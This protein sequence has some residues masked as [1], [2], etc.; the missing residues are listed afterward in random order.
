MKRLLKISFLLFLSL[1]FLNCSNKEASESKSSETLQERESYAIAIHGGAGN[2]SPENMP[3]ASR[4]AYREKLQEALGK[5]ETMLQDGATALETVEQVI[6]ILE[7]SPLFNAGKGAVFTHDGHNELDASIMD[8][9]NLNAG[10]VAGVTDIKNP[11]TAAKHVMMNS[12]HVLLAGKGASEFARLQNLEIVEPSYFHTEKR[13]K[14]LQRALQ[15]EKHGTVGCVVLD[16]HGNLAA[17]TS[18]GGRTNKK[19]GR[20]GDSPIIGAGTYA[21]NQT[22]AVSATGH[23]EYFIRYCVA[24]DI[25][26]LM[27]YKGLGLQEAAD[28]VINEKL[29]EADGAGGIIAVDSMGNI[30]FSFNTTMMFRASANSSGERE[31]AIFK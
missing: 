24:H 22:C 30:T 12:E 15:D 14:S 11:I 1:F 31:I 7:N 17:G 27:Q 29:V 6:N 3:E 21:N 16:N 23:G 28:R 26:A 2:T 20:I 13:W 4:K 5:G 8:G 25:S 19:F 9:S 18:T 10:A